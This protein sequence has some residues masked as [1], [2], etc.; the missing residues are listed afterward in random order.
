VEKNLFTPRAGVAYRPSETMVIRAGYSRNPQ[1]NNPGRQQLPPS[2][3]FPQTVIITQNA[4]NNFSSVGSLSEGSPVVPL[5]DLSSGVL[6]LPA[7]AG[8][9]TFRGDYV[10]GKISSWN[11][12]FQKALSQRMSAQVAYVA[13]RQNGITRNQ[14]LNYG[15]LGGGAASQP[16]QPLG[17][18]SAMNIFAPLGKVKYDSLQ[19]SMNRRMSDGIQFTAAYTYSMTTDWWAAAIAIPEYWD[20]NKGETGTPHK[21]NASL[22]YELPFGSGRRWI[23]NDAALSKITGGWQLNTFFSYQAGTLVTVSSASNVLN[24]PGTTTQFA[25]KV[26]DGPVQIIGD[27]SPNGQYFDVSAF[28]SVTDVRFGNAGMNNF[29]GPSAPNVDMS[30]F[31]TLQVGRNRTLQLRAECFNITNTVHYANPSANISNVTSTGLNG[32]GGITDVVRIGRQ[33]DEREWR[34]GVRFGF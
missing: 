20:L 29:R 2:Q 7:G 8:V 33:Y 3:A 11:V 32:V 6:S 27:T 15:Q 31:R 22:I 9:N 14:N 4:V 18:T 19:L 25:D 13:N 1:S 28:K 12:S 21:L 23:N 24:A 26:K 16:F 5:L 34:L 30:L 10:R 17:I